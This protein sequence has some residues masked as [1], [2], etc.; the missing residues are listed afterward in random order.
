MGLGGG[1]GGVRRPSPILILEQLVVDLLDVDFLPQDVVVAVHVVYD[2]VVQAV[3]LLKQ[4]QL[5]ADS[6]EV[7]ILSHWESEQL[8][9][10]CDNRKRDWEKRREV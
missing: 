7:W 9:A 8:L 1:G 6:L 4:S 10:T 3:Q 5:P 2:R